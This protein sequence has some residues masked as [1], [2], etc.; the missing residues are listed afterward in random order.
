MIGRWVR[1]ERADLQRHAADLHEANAHDEKGRMWTYMSY[2]PFADLAAYRDWMRSSCGAS[3]PMFFA[4]VDVMR[5]AA[6]GL[7]S[8]LRIDPTN[9]CIEVGHLAFSPLLQRTAA[10]TEAMYLMMKR[11]FGAGY[12]RYEWKCDALNAAS[13][14][15]AERLGFC[16]EGT[17]RQ[18]T[19]VKGRNRDT[20]WYSMLDVEWPLIDAAFREWLAESN[21]DA[22]GRQRVPLSQLTRQAHRTLASGASA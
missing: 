14:A 3:D 17:F 22:S 11:V 20:A 16:Y 7:A 5:G 6:V 2:G 18:A 9:G 12:R 19:I 1:L 21:F 15:A 4:I 13:R 8:Y 10:A